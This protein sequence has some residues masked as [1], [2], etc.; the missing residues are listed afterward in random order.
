MAVTSGAQQPSNITVSTTPAYAAPFLQPL[1]QQLANY[2]AGLLTTPTA[3]C[4]MLPQVAGQNVLQQA[5]AQAAA[6][7]AGL[8][9]LQYNAQ[10]QLVGGG[11]C[12]T[13][14]AGYQPF[15]AAAQ[16]NVGPQA[17]QQYMSPYQ[18]QVIAPTLQQYDIQSAINKQALPAAAIQAGAYGGA[19]CGVEQGVYQSQSDLN[20]GL[21]QASLQQQGFTQAQQ[22]A[23]TAFGQEQN[24]ASLQPSLAANAINLLSSAGAGQQAYTQNILNAMTSGNALINQYPLQQLQGIASLFSTISGATPGTPAAPILPNPA[25]AAISAFGGALGTAGSINGTGAGAGLGALGNSLGS[26]FTSL[27]GCNS[28]PA[29]PT[30]TQNALG[31][32]GTV[33]QNYASYGCGPLAVGQGFPGAILG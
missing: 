18:Q 33:G 13:G 14:I 11:T 15:L 6:T 20:R 23:S 16:A 32:T 3:I 25:G 8:G 21:L 4:G 7:Q 5:A 19:R 2:T 17:Y 10:G 24:L 28:T 12:G 30:V 29:N 26:I 27:F 9:S 31:L 1:G 22:A